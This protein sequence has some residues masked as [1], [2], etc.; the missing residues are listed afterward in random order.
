[1]V[2]FHMIFRADY[3]PITGDAEHC[4]TGVSRA[5]A[6]NLVRKPTHDF[7]TLIFAGA[8]LGRVAT[9]RKG[10]FV[11]FVAAASFATMLSATAHCCICMGDLV[12][13][14]ACTA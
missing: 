13:P 9:C 4:F 12:R 2:G 11:R 8:Q 7:D 14:C 3:S 10:F 1:M 6:F 5:I